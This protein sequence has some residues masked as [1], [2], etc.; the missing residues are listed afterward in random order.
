[1]LEFEYTLLGSTSTCTR[2]C[3][4]NSVLVLVLAHCV[5]V[6]SLLISR[7]KQLCA[8][9]LVGYDTAGEAVWS[10]KA[11]G[12]M[13]RRERLSVSVERNAILATHR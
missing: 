7:Q 2:T 6:T 11:G 3:T 5:L 10:D 8:V 9:A 4:W 13:S 12:G 1:L